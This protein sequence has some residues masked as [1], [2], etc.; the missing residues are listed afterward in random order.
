MSL[1]L[2]AVIAILIS[3]SGKPFAQVL[4]NRQEQNKSRL[5]RLEIA[6]SD[7]YRV[8]DETNY[9]L[10]GGFTWKYIFTNT[11]E[12]LVLE[13]RL[14]KSTLNE[15]NNL[16]VGLPSKFGVFTP[17]DNCSIEGVERLLQTMRREVAD[18]Q[19]DQLL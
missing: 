18:Y 3:M 19:K 10:L 15:L 6:I 16:A 12:F 13:H 9:W 4:A 17:S 5:V 8:I 7:F 2:S 11:K 14:S 1:I